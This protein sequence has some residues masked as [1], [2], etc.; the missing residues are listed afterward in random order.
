[1]N[2]P[3]CLLPVL[4]LATFLSP[5]PFAPV[6]LVAQEKSSPEIVI[7]ST[8]QDHQNM[9]QQLGIT[10]LRPG[11]NGNEA[12]P[13]HANYDEAL[14]NPYRALP[15]LLVCRDGTVVKT[16]DEWIAR[17]RPEIVELFEKEVIG[18]IP[19]NVPKVTWKV[20]EDKEIAAGDIPVMEK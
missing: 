1:M 4:I 16:K 7:F 17:R 9:L 2:R 11:P 20:I 5:R 12:A 18:R 13:N 3:T 15:E 10:R 8:M 6:P 19:A 14:A